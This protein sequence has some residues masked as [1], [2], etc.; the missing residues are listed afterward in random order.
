MITLDISATLPAYHNELGT[1]D[2]TDRPV[3]DKRRR[4]DVSDDAGSEGKSLNLVRV[5][6]FMCDG[7]TIRMDE[8]WEPSHL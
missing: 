4:A 7:T 2:V 1:N 5:F 6:T 3:G 8:A